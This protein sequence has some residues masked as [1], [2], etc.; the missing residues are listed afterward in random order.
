M[1]PNLSA[2]S[3]TDPQQPTTGRNPMLSQIVPFQMQSLD[4]PSKL[5]HLRQENAK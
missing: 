2:F 3:E 1:S 4:H 5:R